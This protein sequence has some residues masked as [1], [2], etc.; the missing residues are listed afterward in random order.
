MVYLIS[1]I[2]LILPLQD[3]TQALECCLRVSCFRLAA[4]GVDLL[5]REIS[6]VP[7]D[8]F[9]RQTD[10]LVLFLGKFLIAHAKH[11]FR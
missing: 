10:F 1:A 5:R 6:V 2:G 3:L 7:L 11:P 4:E 9:D 8:L